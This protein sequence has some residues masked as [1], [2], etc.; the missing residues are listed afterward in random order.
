ME[1]VWEK[2]IET[3]IFKYITVLNPHTILR[4]IRLDVGFSLDKKPDG[5]LIYENYN[6]AEY[7]LFSTE[8]PVEWTWKIILTATFPNPRF[9]LLTRRKYVNVLKVV[10]RNVYT[11]TFT[12]MSPDEIRTYGR[13]SIAG[14]NI[15]VSRAIKLIS[16]SINLYIERFRR[17]PHGVLAFWGN[18][19]QFNNFRNTFEL[20]MQKNLRGIRYMKE[21]DFIT[22]FL[23]RKL[24]KR[25][26][27]IQVLISYLASRLSRSI[28][29]PS[30]DISLAL[31]PFLRPPR[32]YFLYDSIDRA[33]AV[34]EAVQGLMRIV[35][36]M[37]PRT[38][39]LIGLENSFT[40]NT[41]ADNMPRWFLS[42]IID[43]TKDLGHIELTYI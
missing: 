34:A 22:F 5:T 15:T 19:K 4:K 24:G 29:M 10:P 8:Y 41:Y 2:K 42:L 32:R 11:F 1:L 38:P 37:H 36:S 6:L 23:R 33:R 17:I 14:T 13:N 21:D 18:K 39:K 28:D 16:E 27:T 12:L 30:C 20:M 26:Y 9:S 40:W 3:N 35:R 31:A 25:I 43:E 7:I